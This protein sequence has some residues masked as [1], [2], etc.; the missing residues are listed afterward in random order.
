MSTLRTFISNFYFVAIDPEINPQNISRFTDGKTKEEIYDSL[1]TDVE[2]RN[3]IL[4]PTSKNIK[5]MKKKIKKKI[6]I[7]EFIDGD[8]LYIGGPDAHD[9]PN[10]F[11]V[12]I[13]NDLDD[14]GPDSTFIFNFREEEDES[15]NEDD[16]TAK[17]IWSTM[18]SAGFIYAPDVEHELR[19]FHTVFLKSPGNTNGTDLHIFRDDEFN[20][21]MIDSRPL[22]YTYMNL[23]V[24]NVVSFDNRLSSKYMTY[25]YPLKSQIRTNKISPQRWTLDTGPLY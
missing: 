23:K 12:V 7:R 5:K 3:I 11:S 10:G 17:T 2:F 4:Y 8:I 24:K 20:L 1:L 16:E 21:S 19:R 13:G 15:D 9:L 25:T 18:S 14:T 22:W 6:L